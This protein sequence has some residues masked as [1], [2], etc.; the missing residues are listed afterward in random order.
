MGIFPLD[1]SNA[2]WVIIDFKMGIPEQSVLFVVYFLASVWGWFC[3]SKDI[4]ARTVKS[5]YPLQ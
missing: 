3:W 2:F 4:K 1:V 5:E